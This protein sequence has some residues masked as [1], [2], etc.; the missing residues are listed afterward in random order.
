MKK[1]F[2]CTALVLVLFLSSCKKP[3]EHTL[4]FNSNGGTRISSLDTS[5]KETV[6]IPK[7]PTKVGYDFG[8]WY[9]DDGT[10]KKEFTKDSLLTEKLESDVTIFAK[11][12]PLIYQIVFHL[13][14]GIDG[15]NP[16]TYTVGTP[17]IILK[18]PTKEKH[19]FVG[20]YN[21]AKFT[22]DKVT[23]IALGS[24]GDI[25][26]HAKWELE[27]NAKDLLIEY[28][29]KT[30]GN[31]KWHPENN[32]ELIKTIHG[33]AITW[34]SNKLSFFSNSGEV[35]RPTY[36]EGDQTVVLIAKLANDET[37]TFN[38]VIK[39][40][41]KQ[42]EEL[43]IATLRSFDE[44]TEVTFSAIITGIKSK[45]V[46]VNDGTSAIFLEAPSKP[47]ELK[48]GDK[49]EIKGKIQNYNGLIRI[50]D[51]VVT[52][53]SSNNE[54][55]EPLTSVLNLD[56]KDQG[57]RLTVENLEVVS[58][59]AQ[60][61]YV[62]AGEKTFGIIVYDTSDK[63]I[64]NYISAI[65]VGTLINLNGVHI[66][67]LA[68]KPIAH[69]YDISN[70]TLNLTHLEKVKLAAEALTQPLVKE[71]KEALEFPIKGLY[72]STI[73][74]TSSDDD[75]VNP[76]TGVINLP[77]VETTITLTAKVTVFDQEVFRHFE[78]IFKPVP[79]V[80]VQAIYTGKT[81]ENMVSGNNAAS[82]GLDPELFTVISS[83]IGSKIK[84]FAQLNLDGEIRL[85]PS[86]DAKG[87]ILKITIA[88]GY[89]I[90]NYKIKFGTIVSKVQVAQNTTIIY[91]GLA[92]A[93]KTFKS[94]ENI[95]INNI[96]IQNI[97]TNPIYIESIEITYIQK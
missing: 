56:A 58:F 66:G 94:N 14:G 7:A 31:P 17:T 60:Y 29:N 22:G 15:V 28:Y 49:V 92:E 97:G 95:D 27:Q 71:D 3:V 35:V 76:S 23:Q 12:N 18:A 26:L 13:D 9:F 19:V 86:D 85:I 40:L 81:T 33:V 16:N 10:F 96:L 47:S 89:S 30:L 70:I 79:P 59:V 52:I 48:V 25:E 65:R 37:H 2:L 39:A 78:V 68:N 93:N 87:H 34:E 90:S 38:I 50:K 36:V 82:L 57:Q 77:K 55:P 54:L 74:W 46:I 84:F 83:Q 6:V 64:M 63:D 8:G 91:S 69:I 43:K 11:W 80:V 41:E 88:E 67:W 32:I 72:D 20:W 44:D 1:I 5:G 62:K 73:L 61:I 24:T 21:N 53:I 75:V 42:E 51:G 4:S 45:M